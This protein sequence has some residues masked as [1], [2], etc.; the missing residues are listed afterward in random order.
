MSALAKQLYEAIIEFEI[1]EKDGKPVMELANR[2]STLR[3]LIA[4]EK[5]APA[6]LPHAQVHPNE[7]A[8]LGK[9]GVT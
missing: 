2:I 3:N 4:Q 6:Q 9:Q 8:I 1:A 7:W 5:A